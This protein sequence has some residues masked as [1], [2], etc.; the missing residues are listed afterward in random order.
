MSEFSP[1]KFL[2]EENTDEQFNPDAFVEEFNPEVFLS[3]PKS[4]EGEDLVID[5]LSKRNK[6]LRQLK[7]GLAG[8][9]TGTTLG[10]MDEAVAGAD[11]VLDQ[12]ALAA[13]KL[14]DPS[15]AAKISE[16]ETFKKHYTESRDEIRK[17]LKALQEE[18]PTTYTAGE[19]GGALATLALPGGA[20]A[21][22]AGKIGTAVKSAKTGQSLA[23]ITPQFV[24]TAAL[25]TTTGAIAGAGLS[26]KEDALLKDTLMGAG[27]GA[28][29]SGLG[30]A[31]RKA[32]NKFGRSA[33]I[34]QLKKIGFDA[35]DFSKL[36]PKEQEA[37]AKSAR[38]LKI[39]TSN[40]EKTLKNAN[41]LKDTSIQ[42]INTVHNK[43]KDANITYIDKAAIKD[44]ILTE[45]KDKYVRP[46]RPESGKY[47]QGMLKEL[48]KLDPTNFKSVHKF[49]QDRGFDL[50]DQSLGKLEQKLAKDT[51]A[52]YADGMK[53]AIEKA[54]T[55]IENPKLLEE[56]TKV[57]KQFQLADKLEKASKKAHH[58]YLRGKERSLLAKGFDSLKYMTSPSR[59]LTTGVATAVNPALL[60]AKLA[61]D[62]FKKKYG[63]VAISKVQGLVD[64]GDPLALRVRDILEKQSPISS[65][66]AK[67]AATVGILDLLRDKE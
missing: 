49:R 22:A 41:K 18:F 57:N 53:E 48:D 44:K 56:F 19:V 21:K 2:E 32:A 62:A 6:K 28:L 36:S 58:N 60:P 17:E 3:E 42:N 52:L 51:F 63:T 34:N 50:V 9:G 37:I 12:I 43:I 38:S 23:K 59:L 1:E 27:T 35:K 45:L 25:P 31:V 13:F 8:V 7:A 65:K 47:L 15:E 4:L 64:K 14:V 39:L 54:G 10:W 46:T 11:A 16:E 33:D 67:S 26:E 66:Q 40:P 5:K 24:K 61:L 29:L 20:L 30:P 55:K